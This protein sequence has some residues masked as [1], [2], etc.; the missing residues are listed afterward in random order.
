MISPTERTMKIYNHPDLE[1][2]PSEEPE[3]LT[4]LTVEKLRETMVCLV[5]MRDYSLILHKSGWLYSTM[6]S[7]DVEIDRHKLMAALKRAD[8]VLA[9]YVDS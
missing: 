2:I 7:D 3:Y 5:E 4:V 6:G 8:E 9:S 1:P